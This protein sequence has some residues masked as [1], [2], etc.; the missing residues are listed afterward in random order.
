MPEIN[1]AELFN[2]LK[3][4]AISIKYAP[5]DQ[6][7]PLGSSKFGG[8]PHLPEDFKWFYY[9][10]TDADE[11]AKNRPLAFIA[12]INLRDIAAYDK[13]KLLPQQGILYF[14]YELDSMTWGF[15]PKDKGSARVYYFDGEI[16]KLQETDFPSDMEQD[17]ILPELCISFENIPDLPDYEEFTDYY[18]ECDWDE[19]EEERE[20]FGY[21]ENEDGA[22]KL[23]GYADIIQNSMLLECEQASNGIFCGDDSVKMTK[24]QKRG[25]FEN[26]KDWTLLF[27]IGTVETGDFEL[28]FGDCGNIY[29]Y[30]KKSDLSRK[31]FDDVWLTLQCG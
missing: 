31:N 10:E 24:E 25:F 21:T 22:L 1:F 11:P 12:Q 29:F 26:S 3:K 23:L 14:F 15:D 19:F 8:K 20:A 17:Y 2:Q 5:A 28:M 6:T 18:G 16:S 30:I 13:E 7:L 4:E 27:Q 9:A